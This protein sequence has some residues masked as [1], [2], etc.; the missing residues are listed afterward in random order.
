MSILREIPPTAG[1]T[2]GIKE[3]FAAFSSGRGEASLEKDF[4]A[5]LNSNYTKVTASGTAALY[6]I[7]NALKNVRP[8]KKVI[9][10][11]YTCPLV[12]LAVKR[13]GFIP[14]ACDISAKDLDFDYEQLEKMCA[15]NS[16][17]A[18]IVATHIGGIPADM[19]RIKAIAS[20]KGIVIIEDCA[21]SLSALYKGRPVGSLGDI[22]FFSLCRGKGLTIYEGGLIAA[23]NKAYEKYLDSAEKEL[24]KADIMEEGLKIL[25]L[26][27]Y[28][29]FYRPA[30]FWL[31]FKLPQ[32]FWMLKKN[33]LKAFTEYYT[34]D[35]PVYK[36]SGVRKNIGHAA[37][38]R[39]D[40]EIESQRSKARLY[41]DGLSSVK[42]IRVIGGAE[43]T[44][45]SYP[46]VIAVFEDPKKRREIFPRLNS[47]GLGVS[48]LYLHEITGYGYLKSVV[49]AKDCP[50]AKYIAENGITL[51]TSAFL[52][53]EDILHVI[54]SIK[55]SLA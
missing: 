40:E 32:I 18:A 3:L 2:V 35:F 9:I 1:F 42:G 46:F 37:F 23:N 54:D 6:I 50:N 55:K 13:A 26:F 7:L 17:I 51:S 52:R 11:A 22:S 30:L 49:P 43:Y 28:S 36:V 15:E 27:G 45:S 24:V 5:Y 8:Q 33:E 31:V 10:P 14:T 20:G 34:E 4:S 16:D 39:L 41:L 44:N 48:L 29:I 38:H 47:L 25:E 19:D 12:A 53:E 21:Q